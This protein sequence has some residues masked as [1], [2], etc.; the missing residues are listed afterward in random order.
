M[1]NLDAEHHHQLSQRC[2]TLKER[3]VVMSEPIL[4]RDIM[5]SKFFSN[6][7][8]SLHPPLQPPH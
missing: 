7:L 4:E 3:S 1:T 5:S 6:L 8:H 2:D